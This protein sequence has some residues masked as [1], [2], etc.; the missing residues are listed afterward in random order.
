ML[1]RPGLLGRLPCPQDWY[2]GSGA[3]TIDSPFNPS[4]GMPAGWAYTRA[5]NVATNCLY[6]DGAT[7]TTYTTYNTNQP[8]LLDFGLLMEPSRTNYFLNSEAPAANSV[9]YTLPVGTYTLW[10]QNT[11]TSRSVSYTSNT[12]TCVPPSGS[13]LP[14][15]PLTFQVTVAGTVTFTIPLNSIRIQLENGSSPTSYILAGATPITRADDKLVQNFFGGQLNPSQGTYWVEYVKT[16]PLTGAAEVIMTA[17]NG[18]YSS[19]ANTDQLVTSVVGGNN[20]VQSQIWA[21][22]AAGTN[23]VTL[24]KPIGNVSRVALSVAQRRVMTAADYTLAPAPVDPNFRPASLLAI[25]LGGGGLST[26]FNGFIRGFKYWPVAMPD[27]ELKEC[28]GAGYYKSPPV[29]DYDF[30]TGVWPR[31]ATFTRTAVSANPT[32]SFYTDL[33]GSSFN[34]FAGLNTPRFFGNRGVLMEINRANYMP[35]SATPITRSSVAIPTTTVFCAWMIGTGSVVLSNGTGTIGT[36]QGSLTLTNGMFT[37]FIMSVAGTVQVTITGSVNRVQIEGMGN[38]VNGWAM[39]PSSFV[40]NTGVSALSRG[41]EYL[42]MPTANWHNNDQYTYLVELTSNYIGWHGYIFMAGL[43]SSSTAREQ[44]F[45]YL[46]DVSQPTQLGAAQLVVPNAGEGYQSNYAQSDITQ[47]FP[48]KLAAAVQILPGGVMQ[49]KAAVDG[50]LGTDNGFNKY[51]TT[52]PYPTNFYLNFNPAGGTGSFFFR[53]VR[54]WDY[55]VSDADLI[56]LTDNSMV[57]SLDLSLT[58]PTL[59]NRFTFLRAAPATYFDVNGVLQTVAIHTPRFGYDPVTHVMRGILIEEQRTNLFLQSGDF[60]NASWVKSN[61]TLAAG[62]PGPNGATTGSGIIGNAGVTASLLESITPTA[63][64]TYTMSCFA[65]AG[66]QTSMQLL[67]PAT[68]FTNGLTRYATFDLTA[69]TSTP[70]GI[71]ATSAIVPVGNGWYR[72]SL[73]ATPDIS[74]AANVQIVRAIAS[75][76]GTSVLFY[77]FGAQIEAGLFATSYIPTTTASAIRYIDTCTMLTTG[78]WFNSA[79]GTLFVTGVMG[80]NVGLAGANGN[81]DICSFD[82][83]TANNTYIMRCNSTTNTFAVVQVSGN[84]NSVTANADVMTTYMPFKGAITYNN[85]VVSACLNAGA[86]A[87]ATGAVPL[88]ITRLNLTFVRQSIQNGWKSRIQYFPYAM[89][90]A[91]LK[92]VTT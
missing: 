53:R 30:T 91:Q 68:W 75:G 65:K 81:I 52:P 60:T 8:R 72:V 38:N 18:S 78:G 54:Y 23:T 3:P 58:G 14:N 89:S 45:T 20:S 44:L 7:V 48:H 51:S 19:N 11:T 67:W 76:D 73:T 69:G 47:N 13:V 37:K 74:V 1:Y 4:A 66:A 64:T 32:D 24:P 39:G 55:R 41:S 79:Q 12:A 46:P 10:H 80:P 71:G 33:A 29:F 63:A 62:T 50:L 87:T 27:A 83:A 22:G 26:T 85:G 36:V 88:N 90:A 5:D 28:T 15:T 61:C 21:V 70:S 40:N 92:Q 59:D 57:P 49:G 43:A 25:T 56:A 17:G 35:V 86:V 16:G 82:D 9:P 77:A 2:F 31:R 84:T 34:Q 6:T 42:I